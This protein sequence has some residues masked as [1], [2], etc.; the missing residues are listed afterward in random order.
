MKQ[1]R[2]TMNNNRG[3][4]LLELIV[5]M[6][7]F[8]VVIMITGKAFESIL[9]ITGRLTSS[10]ESNIEG[11]VGLEMFRHDLQQIGYGL[12][13][14]FQAAPKYREANVASASSPA[15]LL[16]DGKGGSSTSLPGDV[17]RALASLE[18]LTAYATGNTYN[19]LTGTDYLAIKA[20]TV[21]RTKASQKWTFLSYTTA[22]AGKIPNQWSNPADNFASADKVIVLN[23]T[24]SATGQVTNTMVYNTGDPTIYWADYPTGTMNDT[25]F[26]PT[27]PGGVNYLYGVDDGSLGMPFNR[28]DYFVARPSNA[29]NVPTT[30]APGTGILYKANV[31][32]SDGSLTYYPL[33]DCVADMQLVFGWD[34]NGNGVIDESG[35]YDS[36]PVK[37]PLSS[38]SGATKSDIKAI[39]ESPDDIRNKL[40]YVK[41]YVMAQEGRKD[42]NFT[43]KNSLV[44]N[45]L[46]I[47]VGDP[48]P[49]PPSNANLTKGYNVAT[50][51]TNGWLNYRWK[52]Y[53]IVV[54]PKW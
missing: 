2:S 29:A 7:L 36:D 53:R 51:T 34:V 17:P 37:I 49:N 10:E 46:S 15:N 33:L 54:R 44:G 40:K 6:G 28:A 12:P 27:E 48:G 41:V 20:A 38:S 9:K 13:N 52:I 8:I 42:T 35:A 5:T 1:V 21:G 4:T 43:N 45:T 30:C 39:M 14:A 16:N 32:H 18:N 26:N 11:V 23:R 47:V 19:I 3:F 25:A 24:F 22:A 31:N 50:L